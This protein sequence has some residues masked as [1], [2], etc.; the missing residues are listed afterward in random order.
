M[1][2]VVINYNIEVRMF[3]Q[4]ILQHM[5]SNV[6][7]IFPRNSG[8]STSCSTPPVMKGHLPYAGIHAYTLKS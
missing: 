6:Q 2:D 7:E 1:F 4:H 5:Y 3:N 8:I